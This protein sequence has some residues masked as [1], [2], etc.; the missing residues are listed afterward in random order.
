MQKKNYFSLFKFHFYKYL[1]VEF[2]KEKI[3]SETLTMMKLVYCRSVG[4]DEF[5]LDKKYIIKNH[6]KKFFY[7]ILF[8]IQRQEFA[9]ARLLIRSALFRIRQLTLQLLPF[10][11][12]F[13]F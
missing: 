12:I 11:M 10:Y 7:Y 1:L 6:K 5:R 13:P 2:T 3:K 4:I 8:G 9:K